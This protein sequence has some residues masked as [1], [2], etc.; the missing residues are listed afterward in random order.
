LD[1]I[2]PVED[3]YIYIHIFVWTW[4]KARLPW[5]ILVSDGLKLFSEAVAIVVYDCLNFKNLP[6]RTSCS[7]VQIYIPKDHPYL[8]WFHL[9]EQF[10]RRG[11][12]YE[13]KST[14]TGAK[15]YKE[16]TWPLSRWAINGLK[17]SFKNMILSVS[18]TFCLGEKYTVWLDRG[19]N[20]RSHFKWLDRG[21]T[22][23]LTSSDRGFNC[24]SHFKCQGF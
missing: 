24:R 16:L 4:R 20:H 8:V 3:I 7:S 6:H 5:D 15:W 23:G 11:L 10:Y 2:N 14:M 17:Y 9:V 18:N 21:L 13:K 12:K 19:F 22:V 1:T